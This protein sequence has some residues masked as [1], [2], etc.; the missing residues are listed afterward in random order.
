MKLLKNIFLIS[1]IVFTSSC[2]KWLTVN[3]DDRSTE[4]Q[5][6]QSVK[7]F[8][9]A[10]NGIYTDLTNND[11][12]GAAWTMTITEILAQR[13]NVHQEHTLFAIANYAFQQ[14]TVK[15]SM[16]NIWSKAYFQ[17]SSTNNIL[18]QIE[19]R[20]TLFTTNTDYALIKGEALA[21]R[22]M[23]HFDLLRLF[24]PMPTS[25]SQLEAIPYYTENNRKAAPMLSFDKVI[26]NIVTD[27]N[28]AVELL[29]ED[30]IIT[31]GPLYS[32]SQ[33][34]GDLQR[35]YRTLRLNYF[36]TLGL[37][38]RVQLYAGDKQQAYACATTVIDQGAKWFPFIKTSNIMGSSKNPDRIFSTEILFSLQAPQRQQAHLAYFTPELDAKNILAPLP[39]RL[40][41]VFEKNQNDFRYTPIWISKD[42]SE[43][44]RVF[45]KYKNVEDSRLN[46]NNRIPIIRLSEMY[47]IVAE[48]HKDPNEGLKFLNTIRNARGLV[49]LSG[50]NNEQKQLEIEKEYTKEFYGEGQLFFFFKRIGKTTIPDGKS[51][52]NISMSASKYV[53]PLPESETRYRN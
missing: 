21:L 34:G 37:L 22:A 6:F 11:S 16:E 49:S 25:G 14:E 47:Y 42:G 32:E 29:K 9:T 30:P 39:K 23:L 18:E 5:L 51:V 45:A 13:Y 31:E 53:I 48:S 12:Y 17:I 38:A 28:S 40:E 50:L 46:F 10:L 4:D 33:L 19:K 20:K 3:P 26:E 43:D 15:S 52:N 1:L 35:R 36:A 24:G 41:N 27:L 7:G 44:A 2:K 8:Y